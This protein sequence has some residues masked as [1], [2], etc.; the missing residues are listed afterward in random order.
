MPSLILNKHVFVSVPCSTVTPIFGPPFPSCFLNAFFGSIHF[1]PNS[2]C[3]PTPDLFVIFTLSHFLTD[4]QGPK[5]HFP[6]SLPYTFQ[7][8]LKNILVHLNTYIVLHQVFTRKPFSHSMY[9]HFTIKAV[10]SKHRLY[11][12]VKHDSSN[13]SKHTFVLWLSVRFTCAGDSF[14]PFV[15]EMC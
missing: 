7:K 3:S 10:F 15:T 5:V 13:F 6:F 12:F 8:T 4:T 2:M 14:D 1:F 11:R 9:A